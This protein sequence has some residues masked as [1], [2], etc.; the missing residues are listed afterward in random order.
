MPIAAATPRQ[1]ALLGARLAGACALGVIAQLVVH[2]PEGYL[3]G[4]DRMTALGTAYAAALVGLTAVLLVSLRRRSPAAGWLVPGVLALN[5]GLFVPALASDPLVAGLVVVWNLVLLAQHFFPAPATPSPIRGPEASPAEAWLR[6]MGPAVRHLALAALG[7]SVAVVGY[8]LSGRLLAQGVCLALGYGTLAVAWPFLRLLYRAGRRSVLFVAVP[9]AGSVL[10]AA[11]PPLMLSLLAVAQATLL[12]LILAQQQTT[13]EVLRD[14]FDHPSRLIVVSFAT[15]ALFGGVLL[16]FPGASAGPGPVAPLDALFTATSATCVTGLIVLDTPNAF[17]PFGQAVILL[18]I[19]VGGLGIMT[20]STFGAL[21][22]GGSLGLRGERALAEMLDL[23]TAP[24]AYRLTRFIVLSTLAVEAVGAVGLAL[25]Y[26]REGFAVGESI[27][28]GTFHAVSAFC[29]AGFALQSDSIVM[30]QDSPVP[31]LLHAV[32]I[33]LGGLGFVVLAAVWTRVARRERRRPLPV[34]VRTVLAVSA[35]LLAAGTLLYAVCEW[36]RTLAGLAVPDKLV[37]ALFQSVTLRTA[38]FNSVDFTELRSATAFFIILFMFVGAS[39]GST[40]GGIKTTTAAVLL[41][42][43]RSTV[44]RGEPAA[45]FQREVSR[46]IV[47]RSLAIAIISLTV[48]AL[49]LFLLLLFEPQPFLDLAFEA[50]SA[51]GTVGLSLGATARLGPAGKLIII[52]VMFIGRI[53][54]LTVALLLGTST[55][56]RAAVR[57]PETRLMVG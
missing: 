39:P 31:V 1:R 2:M 40:G 28:R 15:L 51:F 29:N 37:N 36:D 54:P 48:V 38:G 6:R 23:Q 5:V 49:G 53:G 14:F 4:R 41:A 43:I 46:E 45:L 26:H 22:L 12:L 33:T 7:L 34:Q 30:F 52:A 11:S 55:A 24:T 35:V 10:A 18:L 27:W 13:L 44:R 3:G 50:M 16:T 25:C 57:Y 17:S 21:M 20:L 19:Q 47:Y 9:V 56:R 42:A 8:R 32:L